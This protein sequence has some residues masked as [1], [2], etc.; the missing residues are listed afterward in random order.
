MYGGHGA[1]NGGASLIGMGMGGDGGQGMGI[2]GLMGG[3]GAHGN[4]FT[5]RGAGRVGLTGP[6]RSATF[7]E[8]K[9]FLGGLDST[10]TKESL[11]MY[12]TKW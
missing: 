8:G 3:Y 7:V 6:S 12:C 11:L 1:W 9:L 4:S 10:T 5:G 2:G